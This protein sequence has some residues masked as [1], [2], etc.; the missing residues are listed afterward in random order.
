MAKI[1]YSEV[2]NG[3]TFEICEDPASWPF[4]FHVL[5]FQVMPDNTVKNLKENERISKGEPRGYRTQDEALSA[6]AELM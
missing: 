6:L 4:V 1:L 3:K 2:I 5:V